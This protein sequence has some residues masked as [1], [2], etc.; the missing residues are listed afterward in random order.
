M[1]RL[2]ADAQSGLRGLWGRDYTSAS[3]PPF[4]F[5]PLPPGPLVVAHRGASAE[6]RENSI[7]AFRLAAEQGADAVETDVRLTSDGVLVLVH[8]P[9][10]AGAPVAGTTFAEL[11][12]RAEGPLATLPEALEVLG[13]AGVGIDLELKNLPGEPGSDSPVEAV[14]EATLAAIEGH[15]GP[16]LL[17]S[18]NWLSIERAR[19]LAPSVETGFLTVPA[20]DPRASLVYCRREGHRWVLPHAAALLSAGEGFVEEARDAGIRVG[21][22]TV[23]D[24]G[25]MRTF[26]SWGVDAV[27]TNVPAAGVAAR[28]DVH[29]RD[30]GSGAQ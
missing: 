3:L 17:S 28:D 21:T 26:F 14:T 12:A 13:R 4:R 6:R 11:C 16:L 27:A 7:E 20:V 10:I 30:R 29:V 22:W 9:V 19:S 15:E 25:T 5:V 18:F 2:E 8:D 1:E 24:P 23:D